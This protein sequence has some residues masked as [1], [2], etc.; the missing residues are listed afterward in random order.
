[1]EDKD[2]SQYTRVS[3]ILYP[4]SGLDKINP[5]IVDN[6]A[7]RGTRVHKICESIILNLG[8][9]DLDE[10]T[11]PYIDSFNHWF[12]EELDIYK[13]EKRFFDDELKITGQCDLI[14]KENSGFTIVDFKTSYKFSKT[15]QIQGC[16]Y[17]YLAKKNG[18]DIKNIKFIHLLK[19]GKPARVYEFDVND[20]IFLDVYKV[21]EYFYKGN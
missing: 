16:A 6:A 19:N 14:I 2:L 13:T 10:E 7:R 21:W 20:E 4:F 3:T 17:A 15:W 12:N 9:F 11:Q 1:M 18:L 5:T 8:A